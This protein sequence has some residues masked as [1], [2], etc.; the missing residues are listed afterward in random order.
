MSVWI[1]TGRTLTGSET[2]G[3][4]T[5]NGMEEAKA[6]LRKRR[7]LVTKIN[8][9]PIEIS[10][11]LTKGVPTKD[12]ARFTRQF[13]AMNSAGLALIQCL[14][15]LTEQVENANLKKAVAKVSVDIQGGGHLV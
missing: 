4:I 12:L 13:S 2:D 1:Y 7:I 9:K 8:K 14:E 11:N 10:F 5:A 3:E 6:L 15:T